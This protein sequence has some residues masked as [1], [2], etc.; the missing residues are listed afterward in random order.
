MSFLKP[1]ITIL[2]HPYN[3]GHFWLALFRTGWWK[4]NQLF[5]HLPALVEIAPGVKIICQ[6][7]NSYGSFIVYAKWPEYEELQFIYNYLGDA[8]AYID[9]GA[10]IGDS[11]LLAA[12][13]IKTG[14][15][16]ACEPTP[17]VFNELVMNI[18]I[19]NFESVVIP[20]QKAISHTIGTSLFALEGASEVNHLS[21]QAVKGKTITVPTTTI[22]HL[23]K[24][25]ALPKVSLLKIDVEGFE[26]EVIQGTKRALQA[27]KIELILFEVNPRSPQIQKKVSDIQAFLDAFSFSYYVFDE[28][29]KLTEVTDLFVPSKTSNF[30]AVSPSQ[31]QTR[32]FKKWLK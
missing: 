9:V 2:T 13:K 25:Y 14:K 6:P 32:K 21:N 12:T 23:L 10:H 7:D 3:Q 26:L 5:F 28:N 11:S 4:L 22:D 29:S 27:K 15:I 24:Q 1:F 17:K 20:L 19:N 16:I 18:K 30:L 31:K 8:D